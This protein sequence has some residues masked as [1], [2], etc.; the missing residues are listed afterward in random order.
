L[1]NDSPE[2]V[3]DFETLAKG[4]ENSRR[5]ARILKPERGY[6]MYKEMIHY[7][8]IRNTVRYALEKGI[9]S[10]DALKKALP[11]KRVRAWSNAG[12]QIVAVRDLD[13]V[14]ARIVSGE[15]KSWDDAHAE[16]DRLWER[17][18]DD[19]AEHAWASLLDLHAL[20]EKDLDTRTWDLWLDRA[21]DT[22]RKIARLTRESR[23]KDYGNPFRRIT[24]DNEAEME[25]VLGGW[26][27]TAL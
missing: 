1:L 6:A 7:Y 21:L 5:K 14:K 10:L 3:S 19:K 20:D 4:I 12:G 24:F 13:A 27:T 26:R 22:Q 8:G 18:P 11:R 16:F 23:E 9:R 25:A 2:T 17:Y 15:L